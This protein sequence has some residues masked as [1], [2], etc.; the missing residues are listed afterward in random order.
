M[1]GTVCNVRIGERRV[2][3]VMFENHR[4]QFTIIVND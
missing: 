1:K 4:I 3:Y 2:Q